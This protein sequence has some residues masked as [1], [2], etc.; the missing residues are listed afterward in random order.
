MI[1]FTLFTIFILVLGMAEG[2]EVA[3]YPE[4][5]D[6]DRSLDFDIS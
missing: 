4:H 3:C 2:A 5:K 6:W 1:L